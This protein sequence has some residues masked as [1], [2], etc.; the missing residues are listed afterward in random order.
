MK[1]KLVLALHRWWGHKGPRAKSGE[2][3][4]V[5]L[6]SDGQ[7]GHTAA[8]NLRL[9]V[10]REPGAAARKSQWPQ[11]TCDALLHANFC[12]KEKRFGLQHFW[13]KPKMN[14]HLFPYPNIW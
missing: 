4:K 10:S 2:T 3:R 5:H 12:K 14:E 13:F 11:S 6:S 8:F 7:R 9:G 1:P